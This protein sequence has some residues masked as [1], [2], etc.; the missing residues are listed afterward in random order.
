MRRVVLWWRRYRGW[1]IVVGSSA[2]GVGIGALATA[3]LPA[4]AAAVTG[5]I[6]AAVFGIATARGTASI[7]RRAERRERLPDHVLTAEESGR[8]RKVDDVGDPL[9]LGVHPAPALRRSIK[10]KVVVDQLPPYVRRDVHD[11]LHDAIGR[12][13]FALI[14]GDSA[15]GK[16]RA[17]Y[18]A[19]R[20]C[21]PDYTMIAPADRKALDTV[22]STVVERR[23]CVVWLDDLERFLGPD[24][25]TVSAVRR[26]LGEGDRQVVLVATMRSGEH[27]R[28]SIRRASED[29]R[30]TWQ[31]GRDVIDLAWEI[32]MQRRWSQ[33]ELVRAMAQN[34]DPRIS[35]ALSATARFGLA[36][37]LA[38]GPELARDWRN[39][40]RV[41]GH[42]R[43]AAIVRAAVDCR[44][45]GLHDPVPK[46]LLVELAERYLDDNDGRALRPEPSDEAL[47][48]AMAPVH[49][50]SSLLIP[51]TTAGSVL[52]FD[53][54]IDLPDQPPVPTTTWSRLIEWASPVQAMNIGTAADQ[55]S[56]P[57]PAVAAFTK[58]SEY[59]V[60]GADLSLASALAM[61]G[62]LDRAVEMATATLAQREAEFGSEHPETILAR[63]ALANYTGWAG[64]PAEAVPLLAE[65]VAHHTA[66]IGADHTT[67]LLTRWRLAT[68]I[69]HTGRHDDAVTE[70]R[71]LL[72]DCV[73]VLGDEH[74]QTLLT[75]HQLAGFTGQGGNPREALRLYRE[76]LPDRARVSGPTHPETLNVRHRIAGYCQQVEGAEAALPLFHQLLDDRQRLLGADHP[77]TLRTKSRVAECLGHAGKTEEAR[78][79]LADVLRAQLRI[80]GPE[81]PD[82][83]NTRYRD[84]IS[85]AGTDVAAATELLGELADDCLRILGPAHPDTLRAADARDGLRE[86]PPPS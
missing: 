75:R 33:K 58:A 62:E 13:G 38:A 24:G 12:G 52:A 34:S 69:G 68:Y 66:T 50:T 63:Q 71:N 42:P 44:R 19:V 17:A 72:A 67:T 47:E 29:D 74:N 6:A 31:A 8:L 40:W 11:H 23:R 61:K 60:P 27:D 43:G 18:E 78:R 15:A 49:G 39:A 14:T 59:G 2:A 9:S 37:I 51:S 21:V 84:A 64:R 57:A 30:D 7:E 45:A 82:T 10:G 36:E 22:V 16:S 65:L 35:R 3:W 81:H 26:M 85:R 28:L 5:A 76:L 32:P 54:L 53:Y 80:L 20:T 25:L 1:A 55:L 46:P 56:L 79:V 48:W 4:T 73:R 41:G 86:P 83:L 70:F 77:E